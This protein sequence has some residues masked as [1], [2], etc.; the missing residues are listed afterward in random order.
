M[1]TG[2]AAD[3]FEAWIASQM[4]ERFISQASVSELDPL[5]L[6][7]LQAEWLNTVRYEG[8]PLF[9]NAFALYWK[10]KTPS[11]N[12]QQITED[13]IR[14]ANAIYNTFYETSR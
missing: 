14:K 11:F 6:Q 9:D 3:D 1:L 7:A 10:Y 5:C 4:Y 8:E 2:K 13:A 12:Y